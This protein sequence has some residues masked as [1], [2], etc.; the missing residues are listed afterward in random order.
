METSRPGALPLREPGVA[1]NRARTTGRK[2]LQSRRL[3]RDARSR[4]RRG[5]SRYPDA[6]IMTSPTER[7]VPLQAVG[8]G[9]KGGTAEVLRLRPFVLV[10]V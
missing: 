1:G 2:S 3:N 9:K 7:P 8:Q 10:K 6:V 4:L 5:R